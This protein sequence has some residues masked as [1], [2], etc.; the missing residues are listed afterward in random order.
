LRLTLFSYAL[1]ALFDSQSLC[2]SAR[3]L[4]QGQDK[5]A[6]VVFCFGKRLINV[7]GQLE[8]A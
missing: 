3:F 2:L 7:Q 6:V 4:G 8:A 5:N 1:T